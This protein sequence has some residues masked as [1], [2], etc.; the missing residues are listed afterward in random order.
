MPFLEIVFGV[1]LGRALAPAARLLFIILGVVVLAG[2]WG[3][4]TGGGQ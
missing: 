2:L 1:A 4:L 3:V